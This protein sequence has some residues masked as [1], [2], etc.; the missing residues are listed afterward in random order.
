[1]DLVS[2][3]AGPEILLPHLSI[4][5]EASQSVLLIHGGFSSSSEW[6]LVSAFLSKHYHLLIPDLPGHGKSASIQPFDMS[7]LLLLLSDLVRARAHNAK[8]HVV[9]LSLGSIVAAHLASHHPHISN[10]VVVS[11]FIR[12]PPSRF[13]ALLPYVFGLQ[14]AVT[15]WLPRSVLSYLMDGAD[16]QPANWSPKLCREICAAIVSGEA[17][18]P[19]PARTLVIAAT[20]GGLI[21]SND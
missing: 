10:T 3:N 17:L 18:E 9:G 6:D 13:A 15:S 16:L 2:H 5:P 12:L 21:P 8:A 19:I 4:N 14:H 11:G 20:K 1:M 7:T